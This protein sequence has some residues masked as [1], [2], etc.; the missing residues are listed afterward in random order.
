[1][2]KDEMIDSLERIKCELET[3]GMY[4]ESRKGY[5]GGAVA[6]AEESVSHAIDLISVSED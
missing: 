6:L 4:A 5:C 2:T 3:V 1:M